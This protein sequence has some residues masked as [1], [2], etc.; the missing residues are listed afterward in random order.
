MRFDEHGLQSEGG[1][2]IDHI[3]PVSLGGSDDLDNLQPLWWKNNR[4]KGDNYPWWG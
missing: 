1:W 2:E 4:R 3:V